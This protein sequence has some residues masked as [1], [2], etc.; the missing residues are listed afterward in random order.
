MPKL[1]AELA[2]WWPLISPAE[3][4]GEA[5]QLYL[6][7]LREAV[8]GA[9]GNLL[10]L[11]C[12]GGHV[13]SHLARELSLTLVD[14]A[15]LMLDQSRLLNPRCSHVHGDM[16]SL[17]LGRQFDA[18][19][20]Q[21]AIS[22]MISEAD[23]RAA[24]DTAF[25]HLRPGGAALFA[26]DYVRGTFHAATSLGGSDALDGSGRAVRYLE[27]LID[28]DPDDSSYEKHHALLLREPGGQVRVEQDS[29]LQGLF[30]RSQW[31]SFMR[32][33]GFSATVVPVGDE[34]QHPDEALTKVMFLGQRVLD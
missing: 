9:F 13:A 16:R 6:E 33:A 26:P 2:E 19:L 28:P 11:G 4:H 27:W 18:V 30:S 20:V 23:L 17:R 25:A 7:I 32:D 14:I 29:E 34:V 8:S 31:L 5:A 1:Y 24:L 22:H 21:D 12:G 3:D 15:P 10:E